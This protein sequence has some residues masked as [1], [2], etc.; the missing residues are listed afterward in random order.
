MYAIFKTGGKQYKAQKGDV[1]RVEKL[2]V[3]AGKNIDITDVLFIGG[4]KPVVGTPTVQGATVTLKVKE[5]AR[6][7]KIIIFKKKRR[8]NYRRKNGHRQ[9]VSIVEVVKIKTA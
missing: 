2:D 4:E 6:N 1:L 8:H 9:P 7:K 3:E 5:Q